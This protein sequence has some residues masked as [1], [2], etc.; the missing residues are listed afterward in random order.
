MLRSLPLLAT[1]LLL[2]L[3]LPLLPSPVLS[4]DNGLALTPPMGWLS[5]ERYRCDIDCA[6]DPS[7]CISESLYKAMAD[8]LAADGF[9]DVGY[10][11]V[12]I[13]DCWAEKLRDFTTGQ[14]VP[15]RKRFPSGMRALADYVHGKGLK[16]GIYGD[17]GTYT[18]G[19]Y[20]GTLGYAELDAQTF[21]NWT[22]D[23]LKLDGCNAA[24]DT[25]KSARSHPF[26]PYPPPPMPPLLYPPHLFHPSTHSPPFP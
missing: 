21:A 26:P 14:M 16:L 8:H 10:T 15:D 7:N 3:L 20:P 6:S 9:A 25:Y 22:I 19:G 13:D 18:C 1:A 23:S 5:W 11:Y 2:T 24:L 12:N 17:W 4:L